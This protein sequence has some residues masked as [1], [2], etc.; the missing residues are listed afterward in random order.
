MII[1]MY[2]AGGRYITTLTDEYHGVS[3]ALEKQWNGRDELGRLLPPG[4]YIM[5]MEVIER[6][7]GKVHRKAQ[8]VVIAV[9]N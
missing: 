4:T 8:P 3:W 7:T 2:D 9:K 1:R 6:S 5:H